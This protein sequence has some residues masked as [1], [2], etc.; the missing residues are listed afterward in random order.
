MEENEYQED[1]ENNLIVN[2]FVWENGKRMT[3]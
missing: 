2:C 3:F 1:S